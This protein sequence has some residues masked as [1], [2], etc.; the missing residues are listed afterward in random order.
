MATTKLN[1]SDQDGAC[2]SQ[3]K[4]IITKRRFW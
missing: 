2:R 3:I 4:K 1:L